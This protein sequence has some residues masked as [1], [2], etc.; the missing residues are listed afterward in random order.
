MYASSH[1]DATGPDLSLPC[2]HSLSAGDPGDGED[3]NNNDGER[4]NSTRKQQII[5]HALDELL[6]LGRSVA[7][8]TGAAAG[9]LVFLLLILVVLVIVGFPSLAQS[10]GRGGGGRG[11][12]GLYRRRCHGDRRLLRVVNKEVDLFA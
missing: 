4:H 10:R 6:L 8:T 2:I 3:T 11:D 7:G 9:R 12:D 5:G 1:H